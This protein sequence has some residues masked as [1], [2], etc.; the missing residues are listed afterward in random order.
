MSGWHV[1][2]RRRGEGCK[3][4]QEL[5]EGKILVLE[6]TTKPCRRCS[7]VHEVLPQLK[8]FRL[9]RGCCGHHPRHSSDE[10]QHL[11]QPWRRMPPV[12]P[13]FLSSSLVPDK[14]K[15]PCR[16]NLPNI[17][18]NLVQ[19]K[20]HPLSNRAGHPQV[21]TPYA[22]KPSSRFAARAASQ[23]RSTV[24][25]TMPAATAT[26]DADTGRT[27]AV[28]FERPLRLSWRRS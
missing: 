19:A 27:G 20:L 23:E 21:T 7:L 1:S 22:P 3:L 14:K 24:T 5:L 15:H 8:S 6:E 17:P 25:T 28:G 18:Q 11:F 26:P 16:N 2:P 12:P 10:I 13:S 4:Y 9:R